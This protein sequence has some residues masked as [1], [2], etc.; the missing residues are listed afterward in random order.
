M[1][2][3][4]VKKALP[5]YVAKGKSA[6]LGALDKVKAGVR[7]ALKKAKAKFGEEEMD[8]EVFDT[9]KVKWGFIKKAI[10]HVKKNIPK[11]IAKGKA[12]INGALEK[13]KATFGEDEMDVEISDE[14]ELEWGFIKTTIDK[15]KKALPKYVAKGKSAILGALDKVKAGVR[16]ALKKAKAKFG[17]EEMDV[18]VFDTDKVKW[19]FIK[20]AIDHVKKNIPKYI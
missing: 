9:D 16:G 17:E 6:I 15:V 13:A 14:D 2:I 5:K 3:D 11:Y 10:D 12:A 8:V 7:G 19:G 18:E 20:K 4:K 1:G